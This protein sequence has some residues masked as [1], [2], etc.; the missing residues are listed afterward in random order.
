RSLIVLDDIL[1]RVQEMGLVRYQPRCPRPRARLQP[2]LGDL[3]TFLREITHRAPAD[4]GLQPVHGGVDA[5]L[6]ALLRRPVTRKIPCS[7][8]RGLII[9]QPDPEGGQGAETPPWPA[10]RTPH[11]D[12]FLY[13]RLG[14][15]RRQMV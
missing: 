4:R 14:E 13:A 7:I 10:I 12:E 8:K 6:L 1:E 2:G 9:D 11:L 3:Q 5:Q 15:D